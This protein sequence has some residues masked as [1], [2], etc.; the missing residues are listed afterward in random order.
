MITYGIGQIDSF[1]VWKAV[2]MICG[3]ATVVWGGVLMVF[4]PN[5]FLSS[6]RFT[7]E[8]KIL[9]IGRGKQNQTV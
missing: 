7:V 9:L 4:L 3:G 6:K 8:E 1:P 2:F 5:S